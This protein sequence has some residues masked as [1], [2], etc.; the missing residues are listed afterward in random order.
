MERVADR[1]DEAVHW[2][3]RER[4]IDCPRAAQA[5]AAE[6]ALDDAA[7]AFQPLR[8]AR[9]LRRERVADELLPTTGR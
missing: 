7:G 5:A 2:R 8:E 3:G 9:D 4:Q 1:R 6:L